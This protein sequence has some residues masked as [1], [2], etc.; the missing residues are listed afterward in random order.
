MALSVKRW[1]GVKI[2]VAEFFTP[3]KNKIHKIGIQPD[4]EIDLPKEAKGIGPK[5][6]KEDTQLQKAIEIIREKTETKNPL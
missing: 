2:T 1:A 6:F 3:K 4:I 5:F